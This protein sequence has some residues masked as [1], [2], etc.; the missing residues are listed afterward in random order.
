MLLGLSRQGVSSDAGLSRGDLVLH[1]GG[2]VA[3]RAVPLVPIVEARLLP[4]LV[5]EL[6]VV[7]DCG[8]SQ[9]RRDL[10]FGG[11]FLRKVFVMTWP[12]YYLTRR[13]GGLLRPCEPR[14][15]F[16]VKE[17]LEDILLSQLGRE[18][19]FEGQFLDP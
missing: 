11:V 4:G 17:V 15:G 9:Q 16:E 18:F 1:C 13:R 10:F 2:H 3:G 19:L 14:A 8:D 5:V 7:I 6:G 12:L